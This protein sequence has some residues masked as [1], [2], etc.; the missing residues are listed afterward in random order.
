[1]KFK[2]SKLFGYIHNYDGVSRS[3]RFTWGEIALWTK[4]IAFKWVGPHYCYEPKL[5]IG[6]YFITF[7]FPTPAFGVKAAQESKQERNYGFY[8]Y[9]TLHNW[10]TTVFMF[11]NKS[12]HIY[13]PWTYE[14]ESTELLDW[15]MNTV[16]KEHKK[17]RNWKKYYEQAEVYKKNNAKVFDY[18]YYLKNGEVQHRKASVTIERRTWYVRGWPWKKMIIT[19][20]DVVF[21]DEVGE[22]SGSWK[23]GTTGCNYEML[24]GETP[25]TT[26]RRMESEREF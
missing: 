21:D 14:W 16:V 11:Y 7:F 10:S 5:V 25:E 26:L 12:W 22:R 4:D 15:D 3:Y 20:I 13:M 24:P 1:M 19:D 9:S 17:D 6:L 18:T 23:G 2:F 8:L